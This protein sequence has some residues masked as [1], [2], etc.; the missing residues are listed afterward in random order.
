MGKIDLISK[1]WCD[2]VFKGKNR[3]YGAYKIRQESG[4]RNVIALAG[5]MIVLLLPLLY[6]SVATWLLHRND[7]KYTD[8]T[9]ISNLKPA[10]NKHRLI[11][12]K[13]QQ[14]LSSSR[15][16][17]KKAVKTSAEVCIRPDK[18][19]VDEPSAAHG[20]QSGVADVLMAPADT[21]GFNDKK[22]THNA[23][24][25]NLDYKTFRVIEQLPEFPGG[26]SA[27]MTWLTH[28]LEY[29]KSIKKGDGVKV[30]AQFIVNKNGTISDLK[31]V[32]SLN[33]DCDAEVLRVL[34][35]MPKWKPGI[36]K[37]KPTRTEYVVPVVFE[38]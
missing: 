32:K 5:I 8:V 12:K 9:E 10:E 4:R 35:M 24:N 13:P 38:N 31:I 19:V 6:F 26:A 28:R 1:E 23:V 17:N 22:V 36:E 18:D 25:A 29:P 16:I 3:D 33:D 15:G 27:F 20:E 34:N 21:T 30:V 7:V 14:T 37:G 11:E 2:I